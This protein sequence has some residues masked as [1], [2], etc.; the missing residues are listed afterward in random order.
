MS[1]RKHWKLGALAATCALTGAAA[2]IIA[3]AGAATPPATP[4]NTATTDHAGHHGGFG[5]RRLIARAVHGD[6][7]VA[8]KNGFVNVTF[9]RGI[10]KSV[11]G[12]Q[13]TITEGTKKATYKTVTLTIPSGARVRDNRQAATLADVKVGQRAIVIQAPTQTYVIAHDVRT[14]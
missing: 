11:S 12:Q 1:L 6:A 4:S 7:V 13:L 10:V 8:T 9:D 3:T 5:P 14:G 2:S